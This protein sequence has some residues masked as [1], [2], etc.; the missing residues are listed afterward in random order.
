MSSIPNNLQI[1]P[2]ER[3]RSHFQKITGALKMNIYLKTRNFTSIKTRQKENSKLIFFTD[4]QNGKRKY[5]F[6]FIF[7]VK[8]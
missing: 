2:R 1:F 8:K 7:R 6:L 3:Q 5:F 4:L